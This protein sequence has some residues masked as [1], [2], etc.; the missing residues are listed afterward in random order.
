MPGWKPLIVCDG[1]E[2]PCTFPKLIELAQNLI[3][4]LIIL[5]TLLAVIA[6]AY[7]GF[8]LITSGGS[9]AKASKAKDVALKV[10]IG[11]MWIL[12]AWLLVYTIT[13]A[14][15]R[16]EFNFILGKPK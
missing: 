8:L 12:V 4:N 14:L 5:S 9:E 13:S 10:L 6:F 3:T 2:V 7:A 16:P 15:L 1:V 11:F